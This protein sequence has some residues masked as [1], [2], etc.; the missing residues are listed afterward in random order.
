MIMM[1]YDWPHHPS[2]SR[3]KQTSG[4]PQARLTKYPQLGAI[5][6]RVMS[7]RILCGV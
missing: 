5:T 3:A 2:S 4:T 7:A 6:V 1:P